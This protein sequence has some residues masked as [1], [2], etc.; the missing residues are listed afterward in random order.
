MDNEEMK[1]ELLEIIKVVEFHVENI[2]KI[3]KL[4][5]KRQRERANVLGTKKYLILKNCYLI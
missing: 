1:K 2:I 3:L 4:R 5:I